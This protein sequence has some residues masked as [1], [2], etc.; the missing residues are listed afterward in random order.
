MKTVQVTASRSYDVLIGRGSSSLLGRR[1][2]ELFPGA[3]KAAIITD[4]NVGA[5]YLGPVAKSLTGA[6]FETV[7]FSVPPGEASK[8]GPQYL[9]LLEWLAEMQITRTDLIVALGG[10]VVGDLAGFVAASYLRGVAFIQIPATLLAMVDSS[11]GGKTGLNLAAGKNLA[12]AFWQPSLVLCDPALLETLPEEVFRD[13][14]AEVIKYGMLGSAEILEKLDG[15]G[16]DLEE[17]I[18]ACV[19]IKADIVGRDE[20]DTGE[21]MLLNLGH[22]IG[23]ALE[24]LS[25]YTLSHGLGVAIGM[26]ID[27]RAAVRQSLCPPRCLAVLTRLLTR[28]KLPMRTDHPAEEIYKAALGDKK[29]AGDEITLITP[30]DFGRSALQKMPQSALLNWIERGLEE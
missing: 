13:G 11:V 3:K 25:G 9:T 26:M 7:D 20:R 24:K 2:R 12:G 19:S 21:R 18:A 16:A 30:V 4:Q 27:T 5:R 29:R 10:G 23:H 6:G 15:D 14:M 8:S 1:G 22:T 17:I 28:Y